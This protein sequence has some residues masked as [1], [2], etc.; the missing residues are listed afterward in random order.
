M[1]SFV[2][3]S[4]AAL[5]GALVVGC[6]SSDKQTSKPGA[7][8]NLT[9]VPPQQQPAP[10][11]NGVGNAAYTGYTPGRTQE[12]GFPSSSGDNDLGGT[13][14]RTTK[15]KATSVAGEP[16]RGAKYTVKKG[17]TLWN[18]AQRAYGNGN[19]FKKIASANSIKGNQVNV[20]Q[21]LT[22]PD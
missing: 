5:A 16:A 4:V 9:T 18:I 20:G 1:K 3:L 7:N 15:A 11:N 21:V 13:E 6:G 19:Q 22:I 8:Q 10:M 2:T 12:T 17:D 14:T